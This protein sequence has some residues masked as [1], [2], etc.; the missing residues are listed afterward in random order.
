MPKR[1]LAIGSLVAFH[2]NSFTLF[3]M[4]QLRPRS[5]ISVH[6]FSYHLELFLNV[7]VPIKIVTRK[8]RFV[9]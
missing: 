3:E 6:F 1:S 7:H 9:G 5:L 8:N 4:V 2:G